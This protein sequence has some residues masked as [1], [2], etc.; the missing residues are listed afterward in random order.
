MRFVWA[1]FVAFVVDPVEQSDLPGDR[2]CGFLVH[3]FGEDAMTTRL[4][5]PDYM[6]RPFIHDVRDE[7]YPG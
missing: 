4:V 6:E 1:S 2:P 3:E 5:A 7:A